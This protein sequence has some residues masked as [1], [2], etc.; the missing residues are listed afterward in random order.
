MPF[1][2]VTTAPWI[3]ENLESSIIYHSLCFAFSSEYPH[4]FCPS[5]PEHERLACLSRVNMLLDLW[6]LLVTFLLFLR[7]ALPR[8]GLVAGAWL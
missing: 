3:R 5:I 2:T 4:S 1:T 6:C 7:I 8:P